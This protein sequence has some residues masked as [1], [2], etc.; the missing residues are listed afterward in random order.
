VLL[1]AEFA[2]VTRKARK[3]RLWEPGPTT[4]S[5]DLGRSAVDRMI[6]HRDP[7]AFVDRIVAFDPEQR[8]RTA[9]EYLGSVAVMLQDPA[10]LV[11]TEDQGPRGGV[12]H[13]RWE[14]GRRSGW[15]DPVHSLRRE[16]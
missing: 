11:D 14:I 4:R 9:A 16:A 10:G 15:H 8:A 3:R 13:E 7:F 12:R 2:D 5:L 1:E 6:P